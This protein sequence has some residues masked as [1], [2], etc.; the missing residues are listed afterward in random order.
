MARIRHIAITTQ[1]VDATAKFYID[2]FGLKEV[3]KVSSE[4]ASGYYLSDGHVNLA[5]L[6][7]TNPAAAGPEF[8]VEYSGIHHIGF[9][10][11]DL[12]A[13]QATLAGLG[14]EPRDDINQALGLHPGRTMNVETKYRAP[15]NVIVD[16][17]QTGWVGT[18][19]EPQ[20]GEPIKA[21]VR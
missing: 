13:A 21:E 12:D 1:D 6:N 10:V 3:G 9:E 17:S 14:S 11:A 20:I 7:F 4:N 5:I 19:P 2:A 16:V 8:G 18:K 15:D